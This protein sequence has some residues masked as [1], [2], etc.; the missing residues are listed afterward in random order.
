MSAILLQTLGEARHHHGSIACFDDYREEEKASLHQK[1]FSVTKNGTLRD[2]EAL[3]LRVNP[4]QIEI[5]NDSD[6]AVTLLKVDSANRP[7]T[8]VEVVQ[9]MLGLNLQIKRAR[10]SSDRSW[11]HDVFEVTE[12]N[13]EKVSNVRKLDFLKRMLNIEQEGIFNNGDEVAVDPIESTLVELAGPDKAGKLAEV[14]RLLTNN[15]C[16]VRSAAVWTY[17]G[18]VAFVLSVLEKGKPIADQVKLQRLR[19]IML[20]IMGPNGQGTVNIKKHSGMVHHDRTLHQMML[21][22]D[23]KAWDQAHSNCGQSLCAAELASR[24]SDASLADAVSPSHASPTDSASSLHADCALQGDFMRDRVESSSPLLRS[25]KHSTPNISIVQCRHTGYWLITIACKDRSKLLFDTVC[26]LAD[27]DYDVYHGTINA[28]PDGSAMQEFYAKPR[29]GRPWDPRAAKKLAAMLEASIQRRFPKGLKLHVHSVDRF[30]SL[31]TLTGVLRDAG[32]T[33]N[34]AKVKTNAANNVCGHT[35]YV[36]DASGA[37]PERAAV[38]RACQQLGGHLVEAGE[39][40]TAGCAAPIA[41]SL[42]SQ[43]WRSNWSGAA[44]SPDS[45]GFSSST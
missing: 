5:D 9:Y 2:Y 7:G 39:D 35:F 18:R 23:S 21:A 43:Q 11:F 16:N 12:A 25:A 31:A 15:G 24:M 13:G 41:F 45:T 8:L 34:R 37:A 29:W 10:I 6:D 19:Q 33:I 38:E 40:V 26:T 14:T 17:Y 44:A 30:G 3:E 22:E 4:T 1:T 32:L 28:N 42:P 27:M 36:M 20:G